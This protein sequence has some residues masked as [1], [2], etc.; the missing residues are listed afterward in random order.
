MKIKIHG[1]E[2]QVQTLNKVVTAQ[3]P[4]EVLIVTAG[5]APSNYSAIHY[6]DPLKKCRTFLRSRGIR[7]GEFT[8]DELRDFY[9]TTGD[10]FRYLSAGIRANVDLGLLVHASPYE[11]QPNRG[12]PKRDNGWPISRMAMIFPKDRLY[13]AVPLGILDEDFIQNHLLEIYKKDI[14]LEKMMISL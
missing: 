14:Q 7:V 6:A 8:E 9:G 12:S 5:D 2:Y 13:I 1:R 10:H 11:D 3:K 4:K